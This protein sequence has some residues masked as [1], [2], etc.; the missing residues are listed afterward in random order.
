M[1]SIRFVCTSSAKLDSVPFTA[2]QIIFAEDTRCIYLDG[3]KRTAY[4]DIIV[5]STE[6]SR[7]ALKS[8]LVGFYFVD[9]TKVLWRYDGIV[10]YPV[11]K[12]PEKQ[13]VFD[14]MS[15]FPNPGKED[16]IYIDGLRMYRYLDGRYQQMNTGEG[17]SSVWVEI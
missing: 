12:P 10:W 2:G 5:L 13:I 17:G 1:A 15:N 4:T 14:S 6:A 11:S 7:Q 3:T 9:E 8:P 16:V